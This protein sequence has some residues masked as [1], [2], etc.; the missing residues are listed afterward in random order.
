VKKRLI[1]A[2]GFVLVAPAVSG[3]ELRLQAPGRD[4]DL[5]WTGAFTA[6]VC[7]VETSLAPVGPWQASASSF[8]S[9]A[10]GQARVPRSSNPAFYRLRAVDVSTNTPAHFTNLLESYGVLETIAGTNL[11]GGGANQVNYWR[12]QYEGG[13]ATNACLSRP[14]IAFADPAN[15]ILLVD[16]GSDSVLR[17]TADGRIHTYAGTH[18]RGFNGDGPAPATNLHLHLPNGGWMRGDGTFYILDTYNARIRRVT[19]NGL[20]STIVTNANANNQGRGLWV[21]NDES[22]IYFCA[23]NQLKR[24]TPTGGV[25]TLPNAFNDL[26][27]V[28]G[29]ER[30]GNLYICD[31]GLNRVFCLFPNG[32]LTVLAG[33][34]TTSGGGDGSPA[35][36]TGLNR[37]RSVW[38]LPNGGFFI[39]EHSPGNRVWYVDPA[40]IIHRW[41]NGNSDNNA[42][43]GDGQWF[44]QDPAQ[45]KISKPRSLVT[46]QRGNLILVESD[47]GFV[48]RINLSRL[49]P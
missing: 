35:L 28:L 36:Q 20:M 46:D 39:S 9:N 47:L 45:A 26:A 44:Y 41:L 17:I 43:R 25:A 27:N 34:G 31:R 4:G 16:E 19:T 40:G 13:P 6:G 24:W 33:N 21:K 8:T 49:R 3:A 14:H 18:V 29:D 1:L 22:L 12:S 48:R 32:A 10:V 30:T 42:Y 7:T 15:H 23:G 11:P 38:F 37:P 2:W 5:R